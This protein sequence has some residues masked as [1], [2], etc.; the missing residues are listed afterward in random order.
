MD[1]TGFTHYSES[2]YQYISGIVAEILATFF[3]WFIGIEK[4]KYP[5]YF[6]SDWHYYLSALRRRLSLSNLKNKEVF[7]NIDPIDV[8]RFKTFLFVTLFIFV[9][10]IISFLFRLFE[11]GIL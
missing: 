7:K 1:V 10:L 11:I 4:Y 9:V 2:I 5:D 3:C 6:D 8:I